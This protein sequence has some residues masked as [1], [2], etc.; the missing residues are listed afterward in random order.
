MIAAAVLMISGC[1]KEWVYDPITDIND[2]QG[3]RVGVN[4]AWEADFALNGRKDLELVR[5]DMPADA[6]QALC[7]DKVDA[8]AYDDMMCKLIESI[9]DGIEK[10]EPAFGYT[11]Y[12]AYFGTDD[13]ETAKDFNAFLTDYKLTED[14][15]DFLERIDS[16][17][18]GNY[19]DPGIPLTGS[20]EVLRIVYDPNNYP[21]IFLEP[22]ESVP[23]GFDIEAFKR[24]ANDRD[25]RLEFTASYYDDAMVGLKGGR[26]DVFVGYMSE[27]FAEDAINYGLYVSDPMDYAP[28]YFM[29][30]TKRDVSIEMEGLE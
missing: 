25:L 17:D 20:G 27:L 9:S 24:Y 10:V 23:E 28:M 29:Q 30:K 12:I 7:F 3:R 14:Y 13:E 21:R 18:G 11:G 26:Y 5:Y 15:S 8:I 4:M 2:L 16:F 22:G 19:E 6:L 1:S